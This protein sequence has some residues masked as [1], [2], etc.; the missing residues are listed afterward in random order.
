MV[1]IEIDLSSGQEAQKN[2]QKAGLGD[3]VDARI[4]DAFKEIPVIEGTFDFVF[5]D[6]W[7]PDYVKFFHL[8]RDRIVPG[9]AIVAH[10]VTNYARDMEDFLEVIKS[11]PGLETT[12]NELS[13]EGMSISVVRSQKSPAEYRD[14]H[15]AADSNE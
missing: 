2:I 12:F 8:L 6:A 4:A 7:K 13:E 10:N 1:T 9:G 3:A 15:S 14:R 11:D 5:I